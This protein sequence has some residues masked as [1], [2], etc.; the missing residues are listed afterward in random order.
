MRIKEITSKKTV[1][2]TAPLTPERARV[3]GL[4]NNVE[5]SKEQLRAERE[6]QR[7][8]R[9]AEQARKALQLRQLSA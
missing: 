5:R 7:Q 2:P 9:S 1:K 3:K 8:Q 4:Q 6:R